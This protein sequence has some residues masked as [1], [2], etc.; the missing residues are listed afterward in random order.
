MKLL[1]RPNC[2]EKDR[3]R[4]TRIYLELIGFIK[5]GC[6]NLHFELVLLLRTLSRNKIY[7]LKT[8][9]MAYVSHAFRQA[10]FSKWT[11]LVLTSPFAILQRFLNEIF[12]T[13]TTIF[14]WEF[15]NGILS[16]FNND[17]DIISRKS[18][19]FWLTET[20]ASPFAIWILSCSLSMSLINVPCNENC[21]SR[22]I[23]VKERNS[24]IWPILAVHG[25]ILSS[26]LGVK[27]WVHQQPPQ[28]H[29][30]RIQLLN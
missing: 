22:P 30:G 5:S 9:L 12:G 16:Y 26:D 25:V 20:I 14:G 21:L 7:I 10:G 29:A 13:K 18:G 3:W 28:S 8:I 19:I 1:N 24:V 15:W 6:L 17:C 4:K 11:N 2:P 27:K 23:F